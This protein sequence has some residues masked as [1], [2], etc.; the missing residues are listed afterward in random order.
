M[1]YFQDL[2][3]KPIQPPYLMIP[4]VDNQYVYQ[5]NVNLTIERPRN[6]FAKF[7]IKI[8]GLDGVK[9]FKGK[10]KYKRKTIYSLDD[11]PIVTI[12]DASNGRKNIYLGKNNK[13][14]IASVKPKSSGRKYKIEFT[15][16]ANGQKDAFY[17]DS[18]KRLYGCGIFHG[19]EKDGVPL[20]CRIVIDRK[21]PTKFSIE[22]A[23]GVDNMFMM[24]LAVFFSDRARYRS[25]TRHHKTSSEKHNKTHHHSSGKKNSSSSKKLGYAAG[26]AAAGAA[27]GAGIAAMAAHNNYGYGYGGYG[28]GG[29]GYGH[30]YGVNISHDHDS[31]SSSSSSEDGNYGYDNN[32]NDSISSSSYNSGSDND[33]NDY[34]G[35]GN[36]DDN[37]HNY[38]FGY[39]DY[40]Y[41]YDGGD[42]GGD[43]GGD[44]GGDCGGDCGGD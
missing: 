30:P 44:F 38:G 4:I 32:D 11:K 1:G 20:L 33:D 35:Y 15:N 29:Y 31:S 36:F 19:K 9:Y 8:K 25:M 42:Y 21:I 7:N 6:L 41:D 22:I 10:N 40:G 12:A 17:M 26:G 39:N 37:N 16:L 24:L 18:D 23:P 28:Y 14:V 43:Y 13:K 3:Q 2:L 34:D 5:Q 27:A